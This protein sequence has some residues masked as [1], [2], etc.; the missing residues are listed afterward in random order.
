[1][2]EFDVAVS[3]RPGGLQS[4]N[5]VTRLP[6][7]VLLAEQFQDMEQPGRTARIV[8]RRCHIARAWRKSTTSHGLHFHPFLV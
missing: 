8:R 5:E 7:R 2:E 6:H 4:V 1:M 3:C